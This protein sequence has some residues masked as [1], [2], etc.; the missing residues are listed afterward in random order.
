MTN[1]IEILREQI[2]AF[3]KTTLRQSKNLAQDVN[4]LLEEI[5]RK[6]PSRSA[7]EFNELIEKLGEEKEKLEGAIERL[8]QEK[9]ELKNKLKD[10]KEIQNETTQIVL[11]RILDQEPDATL[12][13]KLERLIEVVLFEPGYLS[14]DELAIKI[15]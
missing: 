12:R 1:E 5:I 9:Q 11:R 2:T 13:T 10:P 6:L 3:Q 14:P 7:D 15:S 8:E 4:A